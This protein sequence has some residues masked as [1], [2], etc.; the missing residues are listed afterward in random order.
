MAELQRWFSAASNSKGCVKYLWIITNVSNIETK[1]E[2]Q[3]SF[4]LVSAFLGESL[5]GSF[6][7]QY[8]PLSSGDGGHISSWLPLLVMPSCLRQAHGESKWFVNLEKSFLE[9]IFWIWQIFYETVTWI[10]SRGQIF[11]F[12]TV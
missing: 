8:P 3:V 6:P 4:K 9:I 2:I 12:C 11:V 10:L 5:S 1:R 7:G